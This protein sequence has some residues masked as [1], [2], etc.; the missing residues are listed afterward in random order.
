[1]QGT[2]AP[3]IC[4]WKHPLCALLLAFPDDFAS[5]GPIEPM[6][7]F[8]WDRERLSEELEFG[9]SSG[10]HLIARLERMGRCRRITCP[11]LLDNE[12]LILA[13]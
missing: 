13:F 2:H 3:R 1:M 11:P 4:L 7:V 12:S 10:V 8:L 6:E 5:L 9:Q